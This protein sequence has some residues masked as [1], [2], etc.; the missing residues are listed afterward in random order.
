MA[1]YKDKPIHS[2][3]LLHVLGYMFSSTLASPLAA[4][5]ASPRGSQL[6]SSPQ[7]LKHSIILSLNQLKQIHLRTELSETRGSTRSYGAASLRKPSDLKSRNHDPIVPL[8]DTTV[9]P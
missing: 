1:G 4:C 9:A 6:D 5:G 7:V 2:L 8:D 3:G